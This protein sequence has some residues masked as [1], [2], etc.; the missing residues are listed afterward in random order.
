MLGECPAA[1]TEKQWL[2][3]RYADEMTRNVRVGDETFAK[4]KEVFTE[5]EIVEITST[6][7]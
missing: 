6:V 5:K 1:L 2:V 7:S 3:L 4:M